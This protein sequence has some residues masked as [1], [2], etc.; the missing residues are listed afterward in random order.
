MTK[1]EY[2]ELKGLHT[3]SP[4]YDQNAELDDEFKQA[5]DNLV[6][7]FP[8]IKKEEES[9]ANCRHSFKLEKWDYSLVGKDKWKFPCDGFVC[10]TFASE[11][12][13]LWHVGLDGGMCEE[14]EERNEHLRGGKK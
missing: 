4:A 5:V 13:M 9:C 7:C 1:G 8:E 2:A 11:G 14:W 10:D 6:K 3:Y 12:V